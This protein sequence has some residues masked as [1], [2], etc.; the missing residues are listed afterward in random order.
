MTQFDGMPI[1]ETATCSAGLPEAWIIASPSAARSRSIVSAV[2]LP[3]SDG[4]DLQAALE[5]ETV[6]EQH[7]DE[8][9]R[10]ARDAAV[11]PGDGLGH[12][13]ARDAVERRAAGEVVERHGQ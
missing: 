7:V 5:R 10:R 3:P 2:R 1:S 9:G 8:F 6:D 4:V 11:G 13:L 12:A